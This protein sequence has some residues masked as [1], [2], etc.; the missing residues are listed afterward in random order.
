M[1]EAREVLEISP[2]NLIS[3]Q[4]G[5]VKTRII[6]VRDDDFG[7]AGG[8]VKGAEHIP[9]MMLMIYSNDILQETIQGGYARL[10]FYCQY[11]EVRSVK[12]AKHM[13]MIISK[14]ADPPLLQVGFL[15]GGFKAFYREFNG[16][17][18]VATL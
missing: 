13:N 6:D 12:A 10:V 2:K 15:K 5:N 3:F 14:M 11:G 18:H 7:S 1:S 9:S 8:F 4:T 17:E 16:T